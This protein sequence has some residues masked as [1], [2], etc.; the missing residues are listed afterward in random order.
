MVVVYYTGKII[1]RNLRCNDMIKI[2]NIADVKI[3]IFWMLG[4]LLIKK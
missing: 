2:R 1:Y 3:F 4:F